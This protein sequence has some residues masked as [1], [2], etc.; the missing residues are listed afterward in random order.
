M[1][2]NTLLNTDTSAPY[3]Y[4]WTNVPT[5]T[6]DVRAIVYDNAGASAT[7]AAATITVTAASSLPTGVAFQASADHATMVTRYDLRVFA[8]GTDP[9]TA[10]PLTTSD[11]GKPAPDASGTITL[12]RS[13]SSAPW[14]REPTWLPW[15]QLGQEAA[16][17]APACRSVADAV[18]APARGSRPCQ[19]L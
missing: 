12:D 6:Y 7:S 5:G 16:L 19:R 2:A 13:S 18:D 10:T 11:L 4:T 14:R 8:S 17:S 1:P 15:R 3:A 9:N